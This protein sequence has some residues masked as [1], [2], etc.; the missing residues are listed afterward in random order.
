MSQRLINGKC[1]TSF[2]HSKGVKSEGLLLCLC[3]LCGIKSRH[4]EEITGPCCGICSA[5]VLFSCVWLSCLRLSL[6]PHSPSLMPRC[7]EKK[8]YTDLII[9]TDPVSHR[10]P[11]C[12]GRS[13][14][15]WAFREAP[16]GL[17]AR[18]SPLRGKPVVFC[19]FLREQMSKRV[20]QFN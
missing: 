17:G 2:K 6:P 18:S 14:L 20:E 7:R 3:F 15:W 13:C 10:T 11:A 19:R 16:L 4:P 12:P 1:T 8:T 5:L 9:L